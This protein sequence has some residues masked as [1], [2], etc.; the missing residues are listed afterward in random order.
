MTKKFI[1]NIETSDLYSPDGGFIKKVFCPKAV[2]FNQL[3]VSEENKKFR[4]CEICGDKLLDLDVA[5]IDDA[6][7]ILEDEPDTCIYASEKSESVVFLE[8]SSSAS[9]ICQLRKPSR[10]DLPL[11]RVAK[12]LDDINRSVN[13]GYKPVIRVLPAP[14]SDFNKVCFVYRHKKTGYFE[15]YYSHPDRLEH[16]NI[17]L[18]ASGQSNPLVDVNVWAYLIPSDLA[19]GSP[20]LLDT[21]IEDVAQE[22]IPNFGDE[23]I[24]RASRARAYFSGNDVV[25]D[26]K[27]NRKPSIMIG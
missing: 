24:E 5:T 23:F 11:I 8:P 10:L 16:K 21:V 9:I 7:A 18:V 19:D 22:V 26:S 1:Y 4:G 14:Y 15:I 12:N 17:E 2:N 27:E 13:L 6:L 20:I 3:V 25:L